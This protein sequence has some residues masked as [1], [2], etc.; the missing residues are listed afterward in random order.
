MRLMTASTIGLAL[1]LIVEGLVIMDLQIL[2]WRLR[3]HLKQFHPAAYSAVEKHFALTGRAGT[4][5]WYSFLSYAQHHHALIRD[6]DLS[7]L[8]RKIAFRRRFG[9]TLL[10]LI[11]FLTALIVLRVSS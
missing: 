8:T 1:T 9:W 10:F 11:S 3:K 5:S 6:R 4:G 2:F 7:A